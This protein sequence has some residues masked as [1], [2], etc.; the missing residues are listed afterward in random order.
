MLG[1]V[2]HRGPD[3][4]GVY[5]YEGGEAHVGLGNARLSIVDLAGGQQ[6][7]S[8]EDGSVWIVL[9]GEIFNYVELRRELERLGHCFRTASDTEVLVHLFEQYGPEC[10]ARINGQFAFAIWD[11]K[12]EQLL[13]ARDRCGVRPLFYAEQGGLL[14]FASEI[15][16]IL[17]HGKVR[18]ELDPVTLDQIFTYWSPLSP[19]TALAGIRSLPPGSW[20]LVGRSGEVKM[21]RYWQLS[22]PE[23]GKEPFRSVAEASEMLRGLLEDAV[24]LRLRADVPVGAYLSGGLDSSTITALVR[25]VS[26]GQLETFSIAFTDAAFDESEFQRLM[27]RM[28]GTRHHVITCTHADIGQVFPHVIWHTETPVLRTAPGPLFLLSELVRKEGFK[29]VLTGEGADEFLAGYDIFKEAK[30]RQFWARQPQSSGRPALLDSLYPDIGELK[31]TSRAYRRMF[32]GQDLA[33]PDR[34][35]YSHRIRWKNT[36][37]IKRLFSEDFQ[38]A[39][40]GLAGATGKTASGNAAPDGFGLPPDFAR[41][42]LLAR[43]QYLEA[44]VFLSEYLLSSQGDRMAMAHSVEGRFPFLD[45]RV[46]EFCSGLAPRLKLCGLNEKHL[47][48]RIARDIVPEAIWRRAKRPYRA[49]IHRSFFPEGKPLD[50][51]AEALAERSLAAAG[52]FDPEMVRLLVQKTQRF[53][54]LG[55]MDGMALTGVLSTQL[56]YRQFVADF[57]PPP[58]LNEEDNVKTVIRRRGDLAESWCCRESSSRELNGRPTYARGA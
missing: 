52:C 51:V 43:A 15:K 46:V 27:A 50:W 5:V 12:S 1:A 36:C 31:A 11:E 28:L 53:G 39:L 20:L 48:K 47:L 37:R 49:P 56:F 55:E 35:D 17:A 29:V 24:C 34:A 40:G 54:S 9:N 44:T 23:A 10:V 32:F 7:I 25:Q 45:H 13:L 19:R 41:W 4:F 18:A 16:A 21:E 57:K 2:R 42:G 3:E 33:D 8:N 26:E 14:V 30:I 6:P 58:S 22:F 38:A